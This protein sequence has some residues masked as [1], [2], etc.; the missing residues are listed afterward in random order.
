MNK[1]SRD[2][3]SSLGLLAITGGI[4]VLLNILGQY[5]YARLDVTESRAF[6]LSQGSRRV[7][8]ALEDQMTIEAYFTEDLPPPFNTT[9][10]YVRDI[11]AEYE[12]ASGG[13]I[14]TRVI[15]P[16]TDEES[17]EAE[18][19]GVQR[20]RHQVVEDDSLN[21]AEG[22]RGLVIRYLGEKEVMPTIEDT[23]GLEYSLTTSMKTLLGEKRT[24]GVLEGHGGPTPTE[25]LTKLQQLLPNY[26]L[27]AVSAAEPLD[28][29]LAA[30]LV[31]HPKE[32]LDEQELLHI[33]QYLMRGGS[34]GFFGG[35]MGVELE[36][37]ENLAAST[38]DTGVNR[39]L[40]KWG[41]TVESN[42]VADAQ[43]QKMPLQGRMGLATMVPYPPVP[44]VTFDEEEREHPVLFRLNGAVLPFTSSITVNDPGD[45]Q[46]TV[47]ALAKSSENS[48]LLTGS[49]IPLQ[50]RPP[51][52]W[53]P[54]GE[55]GPFNLV[56]SAEGKLPSAFAESQA[57]S[58]AEEAPAAKPEITRAKKKARVLAVGTG[59]LLLDEFVP[60]PEQV[61][62]ERM[63]T[64]VA[65]VL[66]AIDWLSQDSDLIAIRAKNVEE[67]RLEV[68]QSVQEAE[69]EIKEAK[70]EAAAAEQTRNAQAAEQAAD[71]A[72]RAQQRRKRAL[73]GWE[74][75]KRAYRWTN[76]IGLPALLALFG[77]FRW[78]ARTA[79]KQRLKV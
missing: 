75:K 16:D 45:E 61:Q 58:T 54:S 6:S 48:W 79:K 34:V 7:A 40:G 30:L 64:G 43:C 22:Y 49:Q 70:Q 17:Q 52:Q 33:D 51:Q 5:W 37:F 74:G 3:T 29:S 18:E 20:V 57:M 78:R 8:D 60:S 63:N 56:A 24:I 39:L 77:V 32:A 28:S 67:P 1:R 15:H 76:T 21:V 72:E 11:L 69:S 35:T 10:R 23:A 36:S 59:T 47:S 65:I 46:V 19:A 31:I 26:D 2:A 55:V 12:A 13:K 27:T 66:N 73:E 53:R 62:Q 9:E 14:Q 44:L 38:V 68:P 42:L 71:E 4:L 41:L 50:P 25:G